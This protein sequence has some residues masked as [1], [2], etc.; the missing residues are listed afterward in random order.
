MVERPTFE[1][2]RSDGTGIDSRLLVGFASPG[3]ASLVA[4]DHL[5]SNLEA[6]MAGHVNS[7]DLPAIAPFSDGTPRRPTRLYDTDADLSL[8]VSEVFLPVGIGDRFADAV[9]EFADENGV[10]EITALYGVAYPHGPEEHAV[11]SVATESYPSERLAENGIAPLRGG[12][13]DGI[14]GGLLTRGLDQDTPAVG[15]LVTPAHPPGP[16]FEGALLLLDAVRN[17]YGIDVDTAE[18]EER[19]EEVRRYY[20]EL[21]DRM[22]AVSED[23]GDL[24][25][26]RMYM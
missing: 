12:F 26:D 7:P 20:Q 14:P 15:T 17:Q 9:V 2:H 21:A 10:E 11:F 13:L 5:V 16:D 1:F 4:V 23:D 24:P 19:S 8:L 22:Q 6:T 25:E 3:M 18:L